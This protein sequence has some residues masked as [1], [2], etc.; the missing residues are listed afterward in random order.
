M[1]EKVTKYKNEQKVLVVYKINK[2]RRKGITY[3]NNG[4]ANS[5]FN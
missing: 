3:L 5:Q 1:K 2:D 4:Q